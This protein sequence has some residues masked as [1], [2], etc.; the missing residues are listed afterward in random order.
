MVTIGENTDQTM[1]IDTRQIGKPEKL[2]GKELDWM[3]FRFTLGN[4]LACNHPK[5]PEVMDT[6]TK[7]EGVYVMDPN[8]A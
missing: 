2:S 5:L 7:M 6:V 4:F 3:E 1:V 8:I